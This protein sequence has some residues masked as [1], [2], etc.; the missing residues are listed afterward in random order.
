MAIID[1]LEVG[2]KRR[3]IDPLEVEQIDDWKEVPID[4]WK[5]VTV[6][7]ISPKV[8]PEKSIGGFVSNIG[9]SPQKKSPRV[10]R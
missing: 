9:A 2:K 7:T 6:G 8:P 1:P 4:D 5:E 10:I 3:I